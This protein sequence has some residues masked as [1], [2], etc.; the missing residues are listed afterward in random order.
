MS[1][2]VRPNWRGQLQPTH[3]YELVRRVQATEAKSVLARVEQYV[4]VQV[5]VVT[6][7]RLPFG[8]SGQQREVTAAASSVT[9][10]EGVEGGLLLTV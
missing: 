1:Y 7:R 3:L 9:K 5:D 8:P 6:P 2:N 4:S 10:H